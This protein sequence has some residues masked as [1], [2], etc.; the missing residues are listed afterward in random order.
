MVLLVLVLYIA[1]HPTLSFSPRSITQRRGPFRVGI[2]LSDLSSVRIDIR[3]RQINATDPQTGHPRQVN[4][5]FK[6]SDDEA[7]KRPVQGLVL[8]DNSGHHLALRFS[9]TGANRWGEYLLS[10]VRQQPEVDLGPRVMET[11]ERIVR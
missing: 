8:S 3:T 10:A 6:P 4:F 9:R 11:L 1:T 5:Y 7:G 2:D